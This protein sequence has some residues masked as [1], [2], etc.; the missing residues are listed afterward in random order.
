MKCGECKHWEQHK[1]PGMWGKCIRLTSRDC[2][3]VEIYAVNREGE[4]VETIVETLPD[5][6][7]KEWEGK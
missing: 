2:D 7:C 6:F 5:W 1:A 4:W 3:Q